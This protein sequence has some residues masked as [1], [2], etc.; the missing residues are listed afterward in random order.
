MSDVLLCYILACRFLVSVVTGYALV[1]GPADGLVLP[2]L[3][4]TNGRSAAALLAAA[5]AAWALGG[6]LPGPWPDLGPAKGLLRA[7]WA[8]FG[9]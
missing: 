3:L 2:V 6:P 4:S 5:L 1:Q 7:L 9:G 8:A